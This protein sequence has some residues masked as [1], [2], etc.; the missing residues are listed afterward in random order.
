MWSLL[1]NSLTSKKKKK[2]IQFFQNLLHHDIAEK[3][4]SCIGIKH[5]SLT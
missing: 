5:Q 4:L 1:E 3:L 2:D